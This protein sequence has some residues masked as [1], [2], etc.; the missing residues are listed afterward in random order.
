MVARSITIFTLEGVIQP[1]PVSSTTSGD[2]RR[3][4]TIS[5]NVW[6]DLAR[7]FRLAR[8]GANKFA[9]K[10]EGMC[11]QIL[12]GKWAFTARRVYEDPDRQNRI[13]GDWMTSDGV[14]AAQVC[15]LYPPLL[16]L[17]FNAFSP[18]SHLVERSSA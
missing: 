12:E 11:N 17:F 6:P 7:G 9:N 15:N 4:G 18:Q 8:S 1:N 3:A 13:Y 10:K 2:T 14:W 16:A 5:G